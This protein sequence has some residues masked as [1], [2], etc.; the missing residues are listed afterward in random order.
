M[1]LKS[2]RD[3]QVN[4]II[5]GNGIHAMR[6]D[7]ELAYK[8][9]KSIS[10]TR[11]VMNPNGKRMKYIFDR[12]REDKVTAILEQIVPK[13]GQ[14]VAVVGYWVWVHHNAENCADLKSAG[15]RYNKKSGAWYWTPEPWRGRKRKVNPQVSNPQ[16]KSSAVNPAVNSQPKNSAVNLQVNLQ[17]NSWETMEVDGWST[18]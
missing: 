12:A 1:D 2:I 11:Q 14:S 17:D 18:W 16:P 3:G 15:L 13:R 6:F 7:K 9:L 5:A 8:Q 4:S 10:G